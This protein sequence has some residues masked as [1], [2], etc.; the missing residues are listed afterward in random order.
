MSL[1]PLPH[2]SSMF[3]LTSGGKVVL[4][5]PESMALLHCCALNVLSYAKFPRE[6]LSYPVMPMSLVH[7][8]SHAVMSLYS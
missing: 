1:E 4:W 2:A 7:P 8:C 5:L 6:A 3:H